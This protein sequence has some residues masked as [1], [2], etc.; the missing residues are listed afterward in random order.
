MLW[1]DEIIRLMAVAAGADTLGLAA[2]GDM[3]VGLVAAPFT[4]SGTTPVPTPTMPVNA[5][6][7]AKSPASVDV[8][9][10]PNNGDQLIDLI[11]PAGGWRWEATSVFVGPTETLYG[12]AVWNQ[13]SGSLFGSFLFDEP[14]VISA[15]G[16]VV[17]VDQSLLRMRFNAAFLS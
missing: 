7:A 11:P 13:D 14:I 8:T 15:A 17:T 6:L 4:P 9:V 10:D 12:I 5:G 16:Q 3:S 2:G 1:S